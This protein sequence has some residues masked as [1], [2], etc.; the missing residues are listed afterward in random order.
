LA[1]LN[2]F[3]LRATIPLASLKIFFLLLLALNPRFT[4]GI[5]LHLYTFYEYGN[6][7]FILFASWG[8]IVSAFDSLL[9]SFGDFEESR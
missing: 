5:S 7:A 1:T 9:F 3:F 2:T 6:N 8:W 4:L